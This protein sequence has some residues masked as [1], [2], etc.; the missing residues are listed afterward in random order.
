MKSCV[1]KY[2]TLDWYIVE[3]LNVSVSHVSKEKEFLANNLP[4]PQVFAEQQPHKSHSVQ[5]HA[6]DFSPWSY[7]SVSWNINQRKTREFP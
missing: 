5:M 7:D 4:S 1:W 6:L 3:A 2:L